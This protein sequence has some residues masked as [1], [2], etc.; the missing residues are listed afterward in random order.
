[1]EVLPADLRSH[2][3]QKENRRLPSTSNLVHPHGTQ[4]PASPSVG[5]GALPR[6]HRLPPPPICNGSTRSSP[7]QVQDLLDAISTA[8]VALQD[9]PVRDAMRTAEKALRDATSQEKLGQPDRYE[10]LKEEEQLITDVEAFAPCECKEPCLA[11][12]HSAL[13]HCWAPI[14]QKVSV[15][16]NVIVYYAIGC[17]VYH[18]LEGWSCHDTIYF[19]TVTSTTVGYGDFS[20][21]SYAGKAFTIVYA[22]IGITVVLKGLYP[23]VAWLRGDWRER[24]ATFLFGSSKIDTEDMRLSIEEINAKINYSRRYALALIGPGAVFAMGAALHYFAIREPS[25]YGWD[26][27]FGSGLFIVDMPGLLDSFYWSI[28]TMTTIGYGDITPE[29]DFARF[30]AT[31]YLPIAVIA[32]ADA[33]T[34][35][36]MIGLRR[37]IRETDFCK[38]CDDCLLRDAVRD[39]G[40]PNPRPVLTESEFLVDQ[41]LANELV[42]GEA[43]LAIQRQF[44][45]LTRRRIFRPDEQRELTTQMV[46]EE[47][48]E[49]AEQGKI[50]SGDASRV[51]LTPKGKFRWSSYEEWFSQ[52]WEPRVAHKGQEEGRGVRENVKKKKKTKPFGGPMG[53]SAGLGRRGRR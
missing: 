50:L 49:R 27:S 9:G 5:D 45:H 43:V 40:P 37:V 1:M 31:L 4:G 34:D 12:L 20:P 16:F 7:M 25:E 17:L 2:T 29:S 6:S 21:V 30:C 15:A 39:A 14:L 28:I 19:L 3:P 35:V 51:D 42:D 32:L 24:L 47:L 10:R 52:S 53:V 11:K 23:F 46:Y 13:Q 22:V 26:L 18:H 8:S 41:L 44:K 38:N 33:V 48:K 36:Q